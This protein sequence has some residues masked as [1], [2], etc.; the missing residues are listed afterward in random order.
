MLDQRLLRDN[1][2]VLLEGT[3]WKHHAHEAVG[4]CFQRKV[5]A[6]VRKATLVKDL[7]RIARWM[8]APHLMG[9]SVSSRGPSDIK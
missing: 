5:I 3:S 7:Q 9:R 2:M 8:I 4:A 1:V 6:F